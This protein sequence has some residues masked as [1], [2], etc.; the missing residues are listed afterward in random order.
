M[1]AR[2]GEGVRVL[3]MNVEATLLVLP[4]LTLDRHPELFRSF[5]ELRRAI[6][7]DA[8]ALACERATA[9]DLDD[10]ARIAEA[11]AT[12]IDD[13]AFI[14]GDLAFS[15]RLLA[16]TDNYAM[17][18]LFNTLAGVYRA[19]PLLTRAIVSQRALSLTGYTLVL[20]LLRARDA[21][22]VREPLRQAL[23]LTDALTLEALRAASEPPA[24]TRSGRRSHSPKRASP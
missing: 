9:A 18:L 12:P 23:E 7:C 8:V 6:A 2:Q 19:H 5:L 15:R 20:G 21:G 17:V 3:D 24:R 10:L 22:A 13:A 14:D 1:R 4:H 16:A 11:Q